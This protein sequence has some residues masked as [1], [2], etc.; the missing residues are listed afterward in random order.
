MSKIHSNRCPKKDSQHLKN[1]GWIGKN[2]NWQKNEVNCKWK[3]ALEI[4]RLGYLNQKEGI[5][6]ESNMVNGV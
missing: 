5:N 4:E 6:Y 1:N 2:G 3:K